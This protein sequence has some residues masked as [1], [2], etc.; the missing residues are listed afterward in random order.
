MELKELQESLLHGPE[1]VETLILTG[2]LFEELPDVLTK[3]RGL[4]TLNLDENPIKLMEE[5]EWVDFHLLIL[6]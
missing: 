6:S 5:E 3:V 1:H 4:Y 2:N